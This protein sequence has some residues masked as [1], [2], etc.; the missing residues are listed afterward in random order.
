M[1]LARKIKSQKKRLPP[2]VFRT[3]HAYSD[4][5]MTEQT[6]ILKPLPCKGLKD[7]DGFS[8]GEYT[9]TDSKGG[10]WLIARNG[11]EWRLFAPTDAG[12]PEYTSVDGRGWDW[13]Y[14]GETKRDCAIVAANCGTWPASWID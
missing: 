2:L 14:T 11:N 4:R 8:F 3:S 12:L 9:C 10:K 5:A 6:N 13:S 1:H 7:S